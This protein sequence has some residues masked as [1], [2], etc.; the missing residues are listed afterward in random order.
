M[1]KAL[2]LD[3]DGV[4]NRE[5]GNYMC[6]LED[7]ELMPGTIELIKEANVKGYLVIVITNQGGIAK[8]LYTW[9][10]M[11]LI[12]SE[13]KKELD[14]QGATIHHF[15][16][17]THHDSIGASLD[18]KPGSLMLERAMHKFNIDPSKSYMI[19]DK[20]T[21]VLAAEKVGVNGIKIDAN[22]NVQEL[23]LIL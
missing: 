13:M 17:S 19:G 2:F 11:K 14:S 10:D 16:A 21:D 18:R 9:E 12:H 6:R 5:I 22:Q 1:N 20:P 23:N 8:G 15:Y 3:R 7:M 4:I